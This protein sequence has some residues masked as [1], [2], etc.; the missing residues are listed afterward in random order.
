MKRLWMAPD[1]KVCVP[2]YCIQVQK[3]V[4]VKAVKN[5]KSP[6]RRNSHVESPYLNSPRECWVG[7]DKL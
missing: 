7:Q 6:I 4:F 2:F 5:G 1:G 3:L